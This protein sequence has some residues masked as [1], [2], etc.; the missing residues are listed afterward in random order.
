MQLKG[1]QN[2]KVVF[3][4][5]AN[6]TDVEWGFTATK[7]GDSQ[8]AFLTTSHETETE[9]GGNRLMSS[10]LLLGNYKI[11]QHSHNHPNNTPYPS[12]DGNNPEGFESD[13]NWGDRGFSKW[14]NHE[15]EEKREVYGNFIRF[16]IYLPKSK[17]YIEYD[18]SGAY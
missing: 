9:R 2:G 17:N 13:G 11:I 4:F 10:K 8:N 5:L 1:N 7:R 12:G 15:Y 18:E 3:E 16:N 6:N 14:L